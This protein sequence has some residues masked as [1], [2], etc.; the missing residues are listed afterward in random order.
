M[1]SLD[2][3]PGASPTKMNNINMELEADKLVHGSSGK[4][5]NGRGDIDSAIAG[6]QADELSSLDRKLDNALKAGGEHLDYV[7]SMIRSTK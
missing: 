4:K 7:E 5:G 1:F 6:M 2:K 3:V